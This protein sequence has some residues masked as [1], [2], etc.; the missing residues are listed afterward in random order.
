MTDEAPAVRL[1]RC[2]AG[3]T[4]VCACNGHPAGSGGYIAAPAASP[5]VSPSKREPHPDVCV[6]TQAEG[7]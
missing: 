3:H 4:G 1:A 5:W 2:E 6:D 7:L